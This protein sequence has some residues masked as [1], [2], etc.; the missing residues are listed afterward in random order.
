[1]TTDSVF[2]VKGCQ[3]L[4]K[5]ERVHI[6]MRDIRVATF[7][8]GAKNF[9]YYVEDFSSKTIYALR[10]LYRRLPKKDRRRVKSPMNERIRKMLELLFLDGKRVVIKDEDGNVLE[11]GFGVINVRKNKEVDE[12]DYETRLN[13]WKFLKS[14]EALWDTCHIILIEQQFF[15]T[16]GFKNR[17]AAGTGA[18]VKAIKL[19]E[20]CLMW[21][22]D[23]YWPFKEI[24]V[25]PAAFKTQTLGAPD[26]LTKS[27]RKTWAVKK[28]TEIMERR[29]DLEA[30][31]YAKSY[32]MENGRRQKR[33]DM[34]DCVVMTQAFKFV[35]LI[36][37]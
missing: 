20:C 32:R 10:R 36:V 13:L 25:F 14:K 2:F 7:D 34:Y 17:K 33:D 19:G 26:G 3:F 22:L 21:F 11:P 27:K 16:L 37:D 5:G 15:N 24:I 9:A 1:M 12:L 6:N 30:I 31:E 29:G 28:G 35:K 8:I 18:N 23:K 4:S